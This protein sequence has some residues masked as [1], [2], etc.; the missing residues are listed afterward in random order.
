RH[1]AGAEA[2]PRVRDG[3]GQARARVVPAG[4]PAPRPCR[5]AVRRRGPH[6]GRDD[7]PRG[8]R[9]GPGAAR[10]RRPAPVGRR[11]A[12]D[13]L[14]VGAVAGRRLPPSDWP[15]PA[16]RRQRRAV[17]KL[18]TDV[19]VLMGRKVRETLRQP[20]WVIMNLSVPLVLLAFFAP[21]LHSL[22]GAPGFTR[23]SVLDVFVPGM[24]VMLA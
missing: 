1:A 18:V 11:A 8:R 3:A 9:R 14:A 5:A 17:M 24:L 16:R 19:W 20:T 13:D 22:A 23:G 12:G 10:H 21:L 7:P 6:R 2:A 4:G 15:V